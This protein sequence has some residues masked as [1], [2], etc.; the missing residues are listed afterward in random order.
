MVG[1]INK[2]KIFD[3]AEFLEGD[4]VTFAAVVINHHW[5]LIL[6]LPTRTAATT[7]TKH[8]YQSI[9]QLF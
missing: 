4:Q 5:T 7:A 8:N 2:I 1:N 9:H 6:V 3:G